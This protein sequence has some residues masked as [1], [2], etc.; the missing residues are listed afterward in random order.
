VDT[1]VQEESRK[2]TRDALVEVV[3]EACLQHEPR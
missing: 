2:G 1:P 3:P